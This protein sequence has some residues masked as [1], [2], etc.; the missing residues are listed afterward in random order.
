MN[1]YIY[2]YIHIYIYNPNRNACTRSL[3]RIAT[4]DAIGKQDTIPGDTTPVVCIYIYIYI[5]IYIYINA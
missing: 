5:C 2:V 3:A 4:A 1:T